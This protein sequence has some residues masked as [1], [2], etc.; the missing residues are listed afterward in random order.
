MG[1][2]DASRGERRK[3]AIIQ[4]DHDCLVGLLSIWEESYR[5]PQG[6]DIHSPLLKKREAPLKGFGPHEK[7]GV[8]AVFVLK[9]DPVV[10]ED[11]DLSTE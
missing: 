7:N 1:F 10:A 2:E 11:P 8:K 6:D 3:P 9:G 4:G 5:L